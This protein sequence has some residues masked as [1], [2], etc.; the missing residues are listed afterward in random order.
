MRVSKNDLIINGGVHFSTL[1]E[2]KILQEIKH[3]NIIEM[4]DV[5]QI[6]NTTFIVL[7]LMKTDLSKIIL[8]KNIALSLDQIKWIMIQILEGLKVL[9]K[10][11]IMHR[12]LSPANLLVSDKGEIKFSDFGLSRLFADTDRPLTKNLVTLPYRAPEILFG[13]V[14]YGP[15]VDIWAVGWILAELV[16]KEPIFQ[17]VNDLDQLAR[18][19]SILGTPTDETWEGVTDLPDYVEFEEI[20]PEP[21]SNIFQSFDKNFLHL[22]GKLLVL[23]PKNRITL[24]E[25]LDHSFFTEA[26][27]P[28]DPLSIP[29]P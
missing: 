22:L 25:A 11:W 21:F 17:G 13:A 27:Q 8:S 28:W 29:L 14:H 6:K 4:I 10:N 12:D 9:Y 19:F 20:E 3:D 16:L 26:P 23:N 24:E 2:I 1:R 18:I 5:F 15:E 7:E